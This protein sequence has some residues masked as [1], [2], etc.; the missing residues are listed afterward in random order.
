METKKQIE[1]PVE[2]TVT[3]NTSGYYVAPST[4]KDVKPGKSHRTQL[5]ID[6]H[7]YHNDTLNGKA[8]LLYEVGSRDEDER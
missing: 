3:Q 6:D 5:E 7:K 1:E 4:T 2:E 8:G